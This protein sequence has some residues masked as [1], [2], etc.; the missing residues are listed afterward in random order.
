MKK[1]NRHACV[2]VTVKRKMGRNGYTI[3]GNVVVLIDATL[4][5]MTDK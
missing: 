3:F 5:V 1:K 4:S 2:V